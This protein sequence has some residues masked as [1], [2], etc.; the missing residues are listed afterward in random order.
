MANRALVTQQLRLTLITDGVGDLNRIEE[1][2]GAS[3]LGGA[4][5]VQL[6]EPNWSARQMLQ[7]C[8]RLTP[9]LEMVDGLLLVNDRVDVAATHAA[10]GAQIGHRSLPPKMARKVLGPSAILG[11]SA[12]DEKELSLAANH[13]CNFALLSPVWPTTSKPDAA[14]L[15]VKR[16][17]ELTAAAALPVVWL[18]GVNSMTIGEIATLPSAQ[19]PIGIAV[20]SAIMQADDPQA[21][22]AELLQAWPK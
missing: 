18:G 3:I 7:A 6:R 20:R 4:R 11:Y 12:H 9:R 16:A 8:E 5:C 2:V 22:T 15:T 13:D 19:Q 14:S 21:A 1:I 10:H 17:A